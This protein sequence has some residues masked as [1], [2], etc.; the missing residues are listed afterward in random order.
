[1]GYSGRIG[2]GTYFYSGGSRYGTRN[3]CPDGQSISTMIMET[4]MDNSTYKNITFLICSENGDNDNSLALGLGLGLGLGIP[5]VLI[6]LFICYRAGC[7]QGCCTRNR[8]QQDRLIMPEDPSEKELI[9]N[10][11]GSRAHRDFMAGNLTSDLKFTIIGCS[12]NRNN[13]VLLE[14]YAIEHNKNKIAL[15][16]REQLDTIDYGPSKPL[17]MTTEQLGP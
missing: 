5:A 2:G 1:M 17:E 4:L 16:I 7:F 11:L 14:K 3:P 12:R 8:P 15:F 13:L 6:I 9:F 10:M